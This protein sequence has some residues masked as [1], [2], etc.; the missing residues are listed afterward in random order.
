M[1]R[2]QSRNV[3]LQDAAQPHDLESVRAKR[4]LVMIPERNEKEKPGQKR[5]DNDADSRSGKEFKM[6]M[7][8]AEQPRRATAENPPTNLDFLRSVGVG[9]YKIHKSK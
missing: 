5:D 9:H 7:F 1:S 8:L 6:K 4:F 2:F 3:V